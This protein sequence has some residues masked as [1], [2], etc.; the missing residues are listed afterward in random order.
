MIFCSCSIV[1][2]QCR[3][4][5]KNVVTC[6]CTGSGYTG[7][8]CTVDVDECASSSSNNCDENAQCTNTNG[9]FTCACNTGY[10]GDGVS[11][12]D[13]DECDNTP[14][15]SNATC[16]NTAGSFTC[17]CNTGYTGNGL[18][19]NC[20]NIDECVTLETACAEGY[21]CEDKIPGY[22]CKPTPP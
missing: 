15:D 11:C 6:D 4:A 14:C 10:T 8:Y 9:S 5:A 7:D 20:G 19:G 12:T 2:D 21:G 18:P 22:C 17:T 1:P 13:I 16:E 3:L